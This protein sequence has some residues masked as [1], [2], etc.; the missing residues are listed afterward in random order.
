MKLQEI[1]QRDPMYLLPSSSQSRET[2]VQ[3]RNQEI[4]I[5][6]IHQ[7]SVTS[8]ACVRVCL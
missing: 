6:T 4:Y 7:F 2:V 1:I 8:F 3:Y 5:N